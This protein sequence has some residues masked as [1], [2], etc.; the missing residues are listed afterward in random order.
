MYRKRYSLRRHEA[1][2]V[3]T[4]TLVTGGTVI[5]AKTIEPEEIRGKESSGGESRRVAKG[6]LVVIPNGTPHWFKEVNGPINYYVVK[7][8]SAN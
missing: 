5:D 8:R 4:A 2:E 7:V 3:G 6:D 1:H